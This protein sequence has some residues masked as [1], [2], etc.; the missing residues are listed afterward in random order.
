ME[1]RYDTPKKHCPKRGQLR[2]LRMTICI[3]LLC[4]VGVLRA[5]FPGATAAVRAT[6]LPMMETEL[7]Y[8]SAITALGETLTGE[9]GIM[10]VLGDIYIRAFGGTEPENITVT[11]ET[12]ESVDPREPTPASTGAMLPPIEEVIVAPTLPELFSTQ[13]TRTPVSPSRQ[14]DGREAAVEVFLARQ[15]EFADLTLPASASFTYEPLRLEFVAPVE[16]PVTSSFGFRRHPIIREVR[17]HFGTDIAAYTGVPFV[18]FAEGRVVIAGEDNSWGKYILLY[19]GNGI[20]TRYAHAS[21]QYV[22]TGDTVTRGQRIGR[23]GAT[24]TATGPHLHFELRV[25]GV[26]RN[27]EFYLEF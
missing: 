16:G 15:A 17:F 6:V 13:Q 25:D 5:F 1:L 11:A 7:D 21:A 9:T 23:V 19:H 26:Y 10:E 4:A 22:R 3:T 2:M 12:E 14:P 18:A 24:G 27:P 20:Y 8:R